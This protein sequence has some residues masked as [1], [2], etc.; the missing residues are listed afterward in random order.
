MAATDYLKGIFSNIHFSGISST[1]SIFFLIILGS[2]FLGVIVYFLL[3]HLKYNLKIRI[4]ENTAGQGWTPIARDRAMLVSSGDTGEQ[5]LYLKK[6]KVYR[7]AYGIKIAKNTYAF[8]IGTDGYWYNVHFSDLDKSLSELK[9]M[10]VS[11]EMRYTYS[12]IRRSTKDRFGEKKSWIKENFA[13]IL[14]ISMITIMLVFQ[15]LIFDKYITLMNTANAA[16]SAS[17]E[18][19]EAT[20]GILVANSNILHGGSGFVPAT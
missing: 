12:G 4:F 16:I 20:K 7:V 17:K 2:A 8:A 11:Q 13:L 14:G 9:L 1:I 5:V 6:R 19:I 18:V 3:Q 10:P 15:W